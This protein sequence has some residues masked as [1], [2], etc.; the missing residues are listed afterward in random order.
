MGLKCIFFLVINFHIWIFLEVQQ[1]LVLL[2]ILLIKQN[3]TSLFLQ[4]RNISLPKWYSF[5][6]L[7]GQPTWSK[8]S[9]FTYRNTAT[10]P[11]CDPSKSSP[12]GFL[13]H[14]LNSVSSLASSSVPLKMV[15]TG[16]PVWSCRKGWVFFL[17]LSECSGKTG[18]CRSIQR[19]YNQTSPGWAGW[20][21]E[22][23]LIKQNINTPR[24]SSVWRK[25]PGERGVG[26]RSRCL[27]KEG[28]V[29]L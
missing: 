8:P 2:I 29:T 26:W 14:F 5:I 7:T 23:K 3:N 4:P 6:L 12:C 11:K 27:M 15:N 20:V 13:P 22:A 21:R 17:S 18:G 25:L 19:V 16:W 1:V 10:P 9:A 24:E 28:N